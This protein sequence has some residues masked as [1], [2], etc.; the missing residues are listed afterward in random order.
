MRIVIDT[1]H[2][3]AYTASA[4]HF[5][6]E[7]L[8]ALCTC[9]PEHRFL[10]LIGKGRPPFLE[11]D[12]VESL[13]AGPLSQHPLRSRL[14]MHVQLPA[15]V[16]KWKGDLLLTVNGPASASV[17]V[18]QVLLCTHFPDRSPE[19]F[20]KYSG[21]AAALVF[22][23]AAATEN[24]GPL[25]GSVHI[26]PA[27]AGHLFKAADYDSRQAIKEKYTGGKEFFLYTGSLQAPSNLVSLLKSFSIFKR[28]QQS[29][30]RLVLPGAPD[31]KNHKLLT[32]IRTYKYRDEIQLTGEL[33]GE[34]RARITAAAYAVIGPMEE[35]LLGVSGLEAA[36]SAVPLIAAAGHPVLGPEAY[37]QADMRDPVE[38]AAAMMQLYKDEPLRNNLVSL[39]GSLAKR[40][41][42]ETTAAAIRDI[43]SKLSPA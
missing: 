29:G 34:E 9:S 26:V 18:P 1:R 14:W 15:L 39:A 24:T 21:K 8:S 5:T 6:R 2:I 11:N 17:A 20:K 42:M 10:L 19:R 36:L 41:T 40:Y 3:Q 22:F 16:K 13:S 43:L 33:T 27:A 37:L 23:S 30:M 31:P 7:L 4:A 12:R 25:A 28:R 32:S 38:L 35:D